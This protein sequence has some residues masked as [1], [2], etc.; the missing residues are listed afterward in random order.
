MNFAM[1]AQWLVP[2]GSLITAMLGG[3][4]IKVVLDHLRSKRA[5]TDSVALTLVETL[6]ER[7]TTLEAEMKRERDACEARISRVEQHSWL[8]REQAEALDQM[9]RH[10]MRNSRQVIVTLLDLLELAPTRIS[11]IVER[12]RGQLKDID[13]SENAERE[14]F[15]AARAETLKALAKPTDEDL[16]DVRP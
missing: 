10:Q 11:E 13:N 3:G 9:R 7:V 5:Q 2:L 14:A 16:A 1:T 12:T 15:M 6:K 4:L 8:V